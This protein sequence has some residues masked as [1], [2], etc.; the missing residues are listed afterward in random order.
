MEKEFVGDIS[1]PDSFYSS[2]QGMD[3]PLALSFLNYMESIP[4]F[5]FYPGMSPRMK[6][7]VDSLKAM[8]GGLLPAASP[9]EV[10]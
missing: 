1:V 9:N 10:I 6:P 4:A 7:I 5:G 3:E 8:E 2:L